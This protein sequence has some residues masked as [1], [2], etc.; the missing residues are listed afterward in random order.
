M[1]CCGVNSYTDWCGCKNV[2]EITQFKMYS[3]S[4]FSKSYEKTSENIPSLKAKSFEAKDIKTF[5]DQSILSDNDSKGNESMKLFFTKLQPPI[6]HNKSLADKEHQGVNY[7][8][9]GYNIVECFIPDSCCI[10]KETF[11]FKP[12]SSKFVL[13][14]IYIPNLHLN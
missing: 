2:T 1:N 3:L 13:V 7:I 8:Q 11:R 5:S 6:N 10:A 4:S 12:V 14:I 9:K